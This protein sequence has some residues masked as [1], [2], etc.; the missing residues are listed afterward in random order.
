MDISPELLQSFVAVAEMRSF[1]LAARRLGLRQST[2]S[3]HVKRLEYL[4]QRRL[5][6]RDTHS[7]SPTVDGDALIGRAREVLEANTRLHAVF[8]GASL[9]G[10]LR[11]GASEDFVQSG[12][13][14]VLAAFTQRHPT[15]DLALTVGLSGMLYEKFDAGELDVILAKRR[16]GDER[17][18]VVWRERLVWI[19]QPGTRPDPAT[20]LPLVLYPPPSITRS[21]ALAALEQAGRT[22]RVAC[23]SGSLSGIYAATRAGLGVAPHSGMLVPPGLTSIAPSKHLPELSE[24]DFVVIGPK[25]R[26]KVAEA[27]IDAILQ[28]RPAREKSA[29]AGSV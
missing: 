6:A 23:T 22:W 20:S 29:F 1:T 16:R 21:L 5:L 3:Q 8:T 27:V 10:R 13:T 7:V 18:Q 25:T 9:H 12:L 26:D 19:G 11:F 2:V 17:G 4:L 15:V 14:D 28:F 24:I